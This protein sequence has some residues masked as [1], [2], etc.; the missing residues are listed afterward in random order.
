VNRSL[1]PLL[2][3]ALH[4]KFPAISF[5]EIFGL[6]LIFLISTLEKPQY[7]RYGKQATL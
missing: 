7:Q 5:L 4:G 2:L 3:V 6:S 1:D